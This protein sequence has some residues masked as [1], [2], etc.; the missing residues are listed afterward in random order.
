MFLKDLEVEMK[1]WL[2]G[3]EV[4]VPDIISAAGYKVGIS[5]YSLTSSKCRSCLG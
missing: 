5:Q 3:V 1:E 2:N 4:E